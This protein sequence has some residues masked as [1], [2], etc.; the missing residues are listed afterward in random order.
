VN[1]MEIIVRHR[2]LTYRN[3]D[4]QLTNCFQPCLC[5]LLRPGGST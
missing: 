1:P 4:L 2:M 5:P 3:E